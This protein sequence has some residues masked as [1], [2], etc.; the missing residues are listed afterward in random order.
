MTN[1]VMISRDLTTAIFID[2]D[3]DG[4]LE[5][6]NV[7][8]EV[9]ARVVAFKAD[10]NTPEGQA[11]IRTFAAKIASS[12]TAVEKLGKDCNTS[13][14]AQ[15]KATTAIRQKVV[16]DLQAMQDRIRQPLTDI[17]A[18]EK[19]RKANLQGAIDS[20]VAIGDDHTQNWLGY[21]VAEMTETLESTQGLYK[22]EWQELR[23]EAVGSIYG[24]I[25]NIEA[26][27]AK[28]QT[29]DDEQ[30]ELIKLRQAAIEREQ[31]EREE[32]AVKAAVDAERKVTEAKVEA[33]KQEALRREAAIQEQKDQA[34]RDKTAAEERAEAAERELEEQ[35]LRAGRAA[36]AAAIKAEEDAA[37]EK[38][39]RAREVTEREANKKHVD[40]IHKDITSALS[41]LGF[42]NQEA[43][44]LI[45]NINN[46]DI[47]HVR[48]NY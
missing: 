36:E 26:A 19:E 35:K 27:I 11:A 47:P 21:T 40:A 6:Y 7:V 10:V 5:V 29:H 38:L 33:D 17:E 1:D 23:S 12:K 20:I 4:V 31:K 45:E 48:I 25:E 8:E 32:Q 14:N 46:M 2:K 3:E 18:H 22:N 39:T 37:A 41:G 28:R 34:E 16:A 24:A 42:S 9:K 43:K 15:V 44:D 30:A 13:L